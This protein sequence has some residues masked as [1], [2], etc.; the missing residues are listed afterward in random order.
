MTVRLERATRLVITS[1]HPA[2]NGARAGLLANDE[3]RHYNGQV[4]HSLADLRQAMRTAGDRDDV[5]VAIL[6]HGTV[7]EIRLPKGTM[8]IEVVNAR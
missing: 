2:G 8:G 6:R 3:V 4:V 7:L 1:V 5:G